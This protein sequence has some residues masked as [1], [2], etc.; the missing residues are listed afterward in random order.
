MSEKMN[1]FQNKFNQFMRGRYGNDQLNIAVLILG[2][3]LSLISSLVRIEILMLPSYILLGFMIYRAFSRDYLRRSKENSWFLKYWYPVENW[4]L[5]QKR[6]LK[7]MKTYKFYRCPECRQ[8]I[9][10]PK[11]KGKICITCPKCRTEFIKR[12]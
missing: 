12:T 7:E 1:Q 10:V 3:I 5:R 8:K 9:R 11:G 2:V 4:L 6:Q